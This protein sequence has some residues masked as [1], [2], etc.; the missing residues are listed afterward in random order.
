[1]SFILLAVDVEHDFLCVVVGGRVGTGFREGTKHGFESHLVQPRGPV[2]KE[3]R[4]VVV[5]FF[6]LST[7]SMFFEMGSLRSFFPSL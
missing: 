1:M 5:D 3:E 7:R 6:D 4:V 2:G